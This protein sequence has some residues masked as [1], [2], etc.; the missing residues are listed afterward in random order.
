MDSIRDALTAIKDLLAWLPNPVAAILILVFAGALAYSL[1]KWVRKLLRHTLAERYPYVFS[2]FTQMRGV[3]QFA[4][5][6]LAMMIAL[7]VA[8]FDPDTTSWL[9][10][11]LL[12]AV[13]GLIGWAAITAL[14]YRRR[15]L[16]AAIPHRRRRQP[17][18]AQARHASARAAARRR[19]AGGDRHD[20]RRAD[21]LRA[22]AA[23]RR[24]PVRLRRRRRHRRRPRRAPGAQQFVRRRAIGDDA[25]DPHR[26]RGDRRKRMGHHRGDHVDLC[27]GADA[28]ICGD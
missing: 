5:L 25:A 22:G 2:V 15:S 14:N 21:D 24:Q 12:M 27:R 13:I 6:I 9:A 26:R 19:R 8:P 3:T 7:P 28:G 11:L 16:S 1:H 10:R 4:L 20:R 23:I 17:A 18:G